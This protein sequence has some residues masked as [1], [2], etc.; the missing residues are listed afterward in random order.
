[1]LNFS[2][3]PTLKILSL[4]VDANGLTVQLTARRDGLVAAVMEMI[5]LGTQSTM[6]MDSHGFRKLSSSF[7]GEERVYCPASHIS[8]S[9]Y[10]LTKPVVMLL[11]AGGLFFTSMP[12][13]IAGRETMPVALGFIAI[14]LILV[15]A[16]FFTSKKVTLGIITDAQTA[17]VFKL[18]A[19]E[20]QRALLEQAIGVMETLIRDSLAGRTPGGLAP[21]A[22]TSAPAFRPAPSAPGTIQC[23]SCR[24]ALNPG[25]MRSGQQVRCPSC[26]QVFVVP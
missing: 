12:M 16:Y 11:I 25:S 3:H 8:A 2:F 13:L 10:M 6:T 18:K 21:S 24:A 22:P 4:D 23:P 20:D 17:E 9:V 19:N 14:A 26:T 15:V 5:G 7:T 1:M